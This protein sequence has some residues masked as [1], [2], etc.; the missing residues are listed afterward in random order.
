VGGVDIDG[1]GAQVLLVSG[2]SSAVVLVEGGV[3]EL[4]VVL[5]LVDAVASLARGDWKGWSKLPED[6]RRAS[7]RDKDGY[8]PG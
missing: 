4:A 8:V 6:C 5:K 7:H 3:G 2:G 1:L